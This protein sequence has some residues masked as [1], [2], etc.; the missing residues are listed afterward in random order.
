MAGAQTMPPYYNIAAGTGTNA[1]PWSTGTGKGIQW[2]VNSGEFASPSLAPGGHNITEVWFYAASVINATYTSFSVRMG[3]LTSNTDPAWT[4]ASAYAGTMVTVINPATKIIN[5]AGGAWWSMTLDV[6]F[7]YDPSQALVVE[8]N[9]CGFTGTSAQAA[10][11][12]TASGTR[13][14]YFT[15]AS[16][17]QA[18][19][20]QGSEMSPIGVTL[21]PAG[22]CTSPPTAGTST[23]SNASPC[24]GTNITLN[25]TGNSLGSGQTYQWQS[26]SSLAGPYTN[27]GT[28]GSSSNL[29]ITTSTVGTT[30]YQAVVTCSGQNSTSVPIAVTVP[31]PFPGGT[32]TIN[33]AVATGGT[34]FQTFTAA[35][36]AISCGISGPIVFNVAPGSGPYNQQINLPATIGATS[37]NTVTF[38][39]NGVTLG[40]TL[41]GTPANYAT[42]NLDG[43]DY[44]TFKNM[45]INALG[46]TYGFAVHLMNNADN[47]VFDSLTIN[48][49]AAGTG[50]TSGCVS[51]SASNTSY[52]TAGTNGSNNTFSNCTLN[53][54]YFGFSFYGTSPTGN[55][56]N[57]ITNCVVK[58]FYTYGI[59]NLQ[60][61]NGTIANNVV[62]RPTRTIITTMY[63]IYLS[64]GCTNMLVEKN[65][66]RNPSGGSPGS[67]N[68]C[69]SI[70]IAAAS[71]AGNEN[72]IYNNVI[73]NINVNTTAAG[74]Y[75]AGGT[76]LKAF[77]NTISLDYSGTNTGTVYGIYATGTAGVNIRNNN[78]SVTQPGTGTKYALYF[79]GVG[80]LSNY[81]N[82]YVNSTGGTNYIGYYST[83]S[84]GGTTLAAW[85]AVNTNAWDTASVSVNPIFANAAAFDY[86][87][88]NS[89]LDNLGTPVGV[90]SDI[91]GN[92]RSATTPDIGAYEYTVPPCS[93]TPTGGT[94][95]ANVTSVCPGG[96]ITINLSG[97][98]VGT[99]ISIQ[100]ESS[101][102]GMASW[103]A[104]TGATTSTLN[105]TQT[106]GMD[107]HA[108]VTCSNGG[109]S[110][111]SNTISV[112]MSSFLLCYCS[113]LT[114]T[115]LH[116]TTANYI[117]TV[118]IAGTTLNSS[119]SAVGAGGYT[120]LSASI[121]SNT[122]SMTQGQSY[123]LSATIASASYSTELWIDWDQSGTFDAG[124]YTLLTPGTTA[125]TTITVP[126]SAL[127]G[128]AGMRLRN[129]ASATTFHGA[130][131]ACANISLGRET[132]DYLITVV[133]AIQCSG[134]PSTAGTVASNV[135][136]VCGSGNVNLSLTGYPTEL[137]ITYQWQSSPAGQNTYTPITGATA[138]NYTVMGVSSPTDFRMAATCT[139]PGGGTG[140]S[141][142]TVSIAVNNPQVVSTTPG[143]RCGNGTVSLA[144]TAAAG[145]TINWYASATGGAPLAIANNNFT[146]PAINTTTTYYAGAVA[147]TG[148]VDSVAVPLANGTTTGVYF[149]MFLISSVSG[150]NLNSLAIKCNN[151]IGALTS[152]DIYYRPNNYQTIPGANTSSTGWTLLSSVTNVPSAGAAAYT[153][154]ASGLNL[155]IP[156]G[157]TY[158]FHIA[159]SA[160][161][162]HQ[163]ATNTAGTVVSSNSNASII[164]G[165]RGSLFS[166]TTASGMA[167]IK[168]NYSTGCEGTR[169]PVTATV[170]TP[171]AYTVSASPDTLCLG[172]SSTLTATSA[173][174]YSYTWTPG[175]AGNT[176]NVTPSATTKYY[177][178]G[179]DANNCGIYDSVTV[180]V[181]SVP[182]TVATLATPG[183]ICVS[184]NVS[185]SLSPVPMAGIFIQWQ[186]NSGSGYTDIAG[187][188]SSTLSDPVTATTSYQAK[189][190]CNNTLVGTSTPVS[191]TYGN[192]SITDAVP[193]SRCDA[194]PVT[195][196]AK[197]GP[198]GTTVKWYDA[199]TAGTLL[200]SGN[201]FT[202][203]SI[204]ST[205]TYYAAPVT[206]GGAS[207]ATPLPVQSTTN[208]GNV[209]GYWFTAPLGFTITGVQVGG[210]VTGNQS[211]AIVRFNPSVTPPTY[212]LTTN[213]FTTLYLTQNN[214]ATGVIPVNIQVNAG[215]VIGVLGQRATLTPYGSPNP[216][217]TTIAGQA[218]ALNRMG[219]QFPLTTTAPQ[220]L[221]QEPTSTS[222]GLIELTYSVGCEG[223]RVPVTATITGA[224]SG[225]GLST[226]GTTT[227][228]IQADG[229]TVNYMDGCNDKVATVADAA[230]GNVLGNTSAIVLTSSTVQTQGTAPYVPRAFDIAPASNGAAT[231]SLYALQSEFNAYNS[232]VA[233]N[234]LT[235]PLLPTGPADIVGI[236][237]IVVTQYHG[238]A[239][240]GTA[241][242]YGLY[243]NANVQL[244]PNS[245]ITASSN[246][247][248]WTI[249]FPVTGFSGFFIHT[250]S[251][252]LVIDLKTISAKNFGSRNRVDWSTASE[253]AGDKFAV[254]RSSDGRNFTQMGI[255]AAKGQASTYS[256]WDENPYEGISYYRVKMINQSGSVF[257]SSVVTATMKTGGSF[258]VEAYPNPVTNTLTVKL[259]GRPGANAAIIITDVTGK[260]LK[261]IPV[262][263]SS[264][265][266]DMSGFAQGVYL[267]KYYDAVHSQTI[268][269]TKE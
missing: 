63:G 241:G 177:L 57:N 87:P 90:T 42:L 224:A 142:N 81:N 208:T 211:I 189:L 103:T 240:A 252:P 98:S 32:Y 184:G 52:S 187:A 134:V 263:G 76:Y 15:P 65:R 232:Y 244:I 140:Y 128:Q 26:S 170:T 172:G 1:F 3:Q 109:G 180:Y 238:A 100:W 22:P 160:T 223:T 221:W 186:K 119:T 228:T 126:V 36:S 138:F 214:T 168:A 102:I 56:G 110:D 227:A 84:V 11:T 216:Y 78:V 141:S 156:A 264:T 96:P 248:Y 215:D 260:T 237:N 93:G 94:A 192:P 213:A 255:V 130:S 34:N 175:G 219:M 254:E 114:G 164:A 182:A 68:A 20:G 69:Y 261:T 153:T 190:Y 212:S 73:G 247:T 58:N 154:I 262:T 55:S 178:T 231:V 161:T 135:S 146:T 75:L 51:M 62:E 145:N 246:G 64:T 95:T 235:L 132:E 30:Y 200:G 120:Q 8:V 159:P 196:L 166:C 18:Y 222:I 77:H 29:T 253:G 67:A 48:A 60:Q 183:S 19:V 202:S 4:A 45:T 171:P 267:A 24:L 70:Y 46:T 165:H 97:F 179:T 89:L 59:Y 149:H 191:V 7:L 233:T 204:S 38:N 99:G 194:G 269:V 6:P 242:P 85:Q 35:V 66:V 117:T 210:T 217:N 176:I 71:T 33:S 198:A 121:A 158:S 268:K 250:G 37:T 83:S 195:L 91:N 144:A 116:G 5:V 124:E 137:G 258:N 40:Q 131:G 206:A 148:V 39:G 123:A 245:A 218:V 106:S 12:F 236:S 197:A 143:T 155:N 167:V 251:N 88:G 136:S 201:A 257:Y 205:T 118:A 105:T 41:T 9:Q 174:A 23:V 104:I 115:T 152:W 74:L 108:V 157:A 163:Y 226:G 151:T 259:I 27:I 111:V 209:R 49:D 265:A 139:N 229:T 162:T 150:L 173:N 16:C 220:D 50:S 112:N 101:P 82:L 47:N 193:G 61:G 147:G 113:P 207:G 122:G 54:G 243:S 133:A 21:V 185:L 266:I 25:V 92:T 79:T 225:T 230:G 181:K 80:K 10:S 239:S 169:V 107:Y 72:K 53:G 188:N 203:P 28:S 2:I 129:V 44:I 13:R 127:P 125:T 17:V 43:A 14:K 31:T 249:T 86:S 199:A 234:N 256:Y